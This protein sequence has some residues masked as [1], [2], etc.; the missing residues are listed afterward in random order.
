MPPSWDQ[1]RFSIFV[2]YTFS[3]PIHSRDKHDVI[4]QWA[5][6][7][8]FVRQAMI[9]C[10]RPLPTSPVHLSRSMS[11]PFRPGLPTEMCRASPVRERG[12][13]SGS[14][15]PDRRVQAVPS[16]G[17]RRPITGVTPITTQKPS[18]HWAN[19]AR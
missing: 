17:K 7:I 2:V 1:D 13:L 14:V 9:S 16:P 6:F 19:A 10:C 11:R 15:T 5:Q 8:F 18:D 4:K 3:D 12:P